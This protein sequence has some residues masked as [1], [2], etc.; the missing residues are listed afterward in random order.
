MCGFSTTDYTKNTLP[1]PKSVLNAHVCNWCGTWMPLPRQAIIAISKGNC[2][3]ASE[4]ATNAV[5]RQVPELEK[6]GEDYSECVD[7]GINNIG[8]QPKV[9][10]RLFEIQGLLDKD[11]P[12]VCEAVSLMW[13][14]KAQEKLLR[15]R[16]VAALRARWS[17]RSFNAL[18]WLPSP[19]VSTTGQYTTDPNTGECKT[20]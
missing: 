17:G 16:R 19:H 11:A 14:D 2:T 12:M 8:I 20:Q 7:L 4:V 3:E 15:A 18:P 9:S 10:N 5:V 1:V 6:T 13:G